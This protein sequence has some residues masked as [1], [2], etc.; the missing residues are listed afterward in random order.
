MYTQTGKH[1]GALMHVYMR[2]TESV[3]YI[4]HNNTFSALPTLYF[5]ISS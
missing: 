4:K 1:K 2:L 5:A 3:I